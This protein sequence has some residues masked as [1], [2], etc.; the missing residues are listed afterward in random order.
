MGNSHTDCFRCLCSAIQPQKLRSW[1]VLAKSLTDAGFEITASW[2][3]STENF[4][5]L[6][7]AQKNAVSSTVLLVCCKRDRNIKAEL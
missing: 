6:H 4:Q 5:N 2:T 3:V 1:D 7:Q